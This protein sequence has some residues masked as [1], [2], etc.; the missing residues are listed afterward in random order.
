MAASFTE[1]L[2]GLSYED[3]L[4][5]VRKIIDKIVATKEEI[6]LCGFIPVYETVSETKVGLRAKYRNRRSTKCR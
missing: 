2:T 1:F 6:K 5:T 3:K 4:F